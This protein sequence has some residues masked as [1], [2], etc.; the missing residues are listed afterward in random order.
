MTQDGESR[1]EAILPT[2]ILST[3]ATI[4]IGTWN[5]QTMYQAGKTAQVA[6]EMKAY[7]LDVLGI[8]EARWTGSGHLLLDSGLKLLYS[9]HE[10]KDAPHTS[11]EGVVRMLSKKAHCSLIG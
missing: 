8:S 2:T 7:G 11:T 10:G 6:K 9:G 4:K 1:K 3:R 5:V